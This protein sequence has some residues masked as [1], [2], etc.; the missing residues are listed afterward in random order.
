M[1][2]ESADQAIDDLDAL[3]TGLYLAKAGAPSWLES[4]VMQLNRLDAIAD[5]IL[6][7]HFSQIHH[8][9][10]TLATTADTH[11]KQRALRRALDGTEALRKLVRSRAL[12]ASFARLA[13]Q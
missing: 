2:F 9:A 3:L 6:R 13:C 1:G 7:F 10:T 4:I 11:A 8:H 5:D 12:V